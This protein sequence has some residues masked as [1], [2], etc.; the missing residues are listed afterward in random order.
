MHTLKRSVR[1]FL[2][3]FARKQFSVVLEKDV[4]GY[5]R[6]TRMTVVR[7]HNGGVRSLG[8]IGKRHLIFAKAPDGTT[9]PLIREDVTSGK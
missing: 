1:A 8:A 7:S 9:I 5:P 4:H 6:G 2:K 3:L